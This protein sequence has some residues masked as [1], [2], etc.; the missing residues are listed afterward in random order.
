MAEYATALKLGTTGLVLQLIED[1]KAP[2]DLD[3]DEPV[4]TLQE[5]SQDQERQWMVRLQSGKRISAIDVQEEFLAAAQAHCKGQDEETDWVL[6]QWES[7]L[8][9]LR[10]DYSQLIGRVDWASK[11]W[12]LETFRE[13]D[14]LEWNDPIL[15]SLD[16]EYHNLHPEKGLYHGLVEEGGCRDSPP[17]KSLSLP[18][19]IPRATRGPSDRGELVKHLL[20]CGQ[21]AEAHAAGKDER[22]FPA[23]VI[24]WSIFQVRGR[25][26]FAM[27]DPFKTYVQE[28][29]SY[30]A[31]PLTHNLL[32]NM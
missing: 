31:S 28:V 23:Y 25:E 17:I 11:L 26:A 21:P 7:V 1:G 14:R 27:A 19:S 16:L 3:I 12:L 5:I 9:D 4:E 13:A 20:T 32:M 15:K 22:F 29:R 10:G 2:R 18:P 8:H 30:L 24:N 6:A